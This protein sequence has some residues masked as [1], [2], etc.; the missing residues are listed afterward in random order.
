MPEHATTFDQLIPRY[1]CQQ[2]RQNMP[3][4]TNQIMAT[5]DPETNTEYLAKAIS[6]DKLFRFTFNEFTYKV[7]GALTAQV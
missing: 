4:T 6:P 2:Y 3:V 1:V 5:F 7:M